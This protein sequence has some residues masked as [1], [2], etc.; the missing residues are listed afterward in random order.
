LDPDNEFQPDAAL[1][2][3]A[4]CG[5]QARIDEDD[6]IAG[7]PEFIGEISASTKSID[8]TK[9][10]RV[11]RRN[12]VREYVVWRVEDAEI[13]W[14]VLR[15]SQFERLPLDASGWYRSDVFPGLWLDPA[16]MVR[17]DMARVL[18]VVQQGIASPEHG[19]FVADLARR[20]AS[21]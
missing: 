17:G 11:Y 16:A 14:F 18:E 10:L 19:Q 3:L 5:G 1:L 7:G 9:K 6:Y 21:S 2:I 20:K 8:V 15:Q 12:K 13:D 4:E